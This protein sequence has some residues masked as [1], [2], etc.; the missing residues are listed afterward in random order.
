LVLLLTVTPVAV[1]QF[2][3]ILSQMNK[4][5]AYIRLLINGMG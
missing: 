1:E 5:G 4:E 2:K 3:E